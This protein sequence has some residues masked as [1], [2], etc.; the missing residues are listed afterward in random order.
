MDSIGLGNTILQNI[1]SPGLQRSLLPVKLILILISLV[2]IILII[3][4]FRKS[5][6][7]NFLYLDWV[8]NRKLLKSIRI[9][10]LDE[11]EGV[12]AQKEEV[13]DEIQAQPQKLP[14]SQRGSHSQPKED[15]E[16]FIETKKK[17]VEKVEISDWQRILD[18]LETKDQLKCKL[19]LLD[20]DRLF[21]KSLSQKEKELK[22]LSNFEKIEKIKDYLERLLDHPNKGITFRNANNIIREYKIALKEIGAI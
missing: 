7:K 1:I 15:E 13:K 14:Q 11:K 10:E 22:S 18:K 5:S 17:E 3:W 4:L 20:A 6:Y 16:D 2:A 8:N 12:I 19:A 21:D 9:G